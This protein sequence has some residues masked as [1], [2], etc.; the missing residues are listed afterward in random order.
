VNTFVCKVVGIL[1]NKFH[2]LCFGYNVI[3]G[4]VHNQDHSSTYLIRNAV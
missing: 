4:L 2:I 1:A 3:L